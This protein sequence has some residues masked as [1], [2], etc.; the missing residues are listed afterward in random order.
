MVSSSKKSIKRIWK[1][2]IISFFAF[3]IISLTLTKVIYDFTFSRYDV[4]ANIP[5]SLSQF[6]S[7][8]QEMNF[9]SG[10]NNLC[11]Y[12]YKGS[13]ES[14][15]IL[16]TGY[17]AV[18]DD[19]I[20]QIKELNDKGYGVFTFDTTGYLKSEGKDARGFAQTV[21]DLKSALEFLD[22][23]YNFG[24]E[25]IYLLG[26]SRGAYAVLS[27]LDDGYDI[28]AT[29]SVSGVNSSME[30]VI[31]PA[32]DKVGFIAYINYPFLWLYQNAI[33]DTETLNTKATDNILNS[34]IPFLVVQGENDETYPPDKYSVYSHIKNESENVSLL[35]MDEKGSDG[36]TNLLFDADGTANDELINSIDDFLKNEGRKSK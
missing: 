1:T 22:K 7:D 24:Y 29:V 14:L 20:W 2:I 25:N 13:S 5:E 17:R 28:K 12:F 32:A 9:K 15:I 3:I 11:G 19:Y 23:N 30:A 34:N 10:E 31:Q 21:Y 8:R 6:L 36:H 35:I 26:H 33:F 18:A 4:A 16:V 27:V